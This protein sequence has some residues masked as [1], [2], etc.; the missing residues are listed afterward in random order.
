MAR[1]VG[2]NLIKLG[3]W[4]SERKWGLESKIA[5]SMGKRYLK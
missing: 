2:N 3:F 5:V 4:N 1:T